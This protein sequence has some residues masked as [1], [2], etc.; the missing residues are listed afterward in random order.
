VTKIITAILGVL[1]LV[2]GV[3]SLLL[4]RQDRVAAQA[5]DESFAQAESAQPSNCRDIIRDVSLSKRVMTEKE[6]QTLRIVVANIGGAGI[7]NTAVRL[8]ALDFEL[9]PA[10]TERVVALEPDGNPVALLWILKPKETGSFE[11]AL[12]AGEQTQV[13][14]I[15]V[16]NVLG[17]TAVQIQI[18]S[19]ISSFL[20]PML[21]APW[22][23]EQWEKRQEA[24]KETAEKA[25]AVSGQA[26][27]PKTGER[28]QP[29]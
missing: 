23:Y 6:S 5:V 15:V 14:G 10:A 25:A 7:C 1:L 26:E 11:I 17:F 21:T 22:W 20:G 16:T 8:A 24:K 12:T 3:S 27:Q 2:L 9:A 18:L 28:F 29:E 4:L 13:L 19:Y